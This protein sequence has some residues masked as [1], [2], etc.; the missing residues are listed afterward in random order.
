[1]KGRAV[2]GEAYRRQPWQ[3][4]C[5][6]DTHT[7]THTHTC[8]REGAALRGYVDEVVGTCVRAHTRTR[9][10]RHLHGLVFQVSMCPIAIVVCVG[11]FHPRLSQQ[12]Q[13]QSHSYHSEPITWCCR[14]RYVC[15]PNAF[16]MCRCHV[17]AQDA[18]YIVCVTVE[19]CVTLA[20]WVMCPSGPS[21]CTC[22][23]CR[24]E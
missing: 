1:M 10:I 6:L 12:C 2:E 21:P 22:D 7:H 14:V 3:H 15:D 11:R 5:V 17:C 4:R 24:H 23:M 16:A 9:T 13:Q 20:T 19:N 18:I 8:G